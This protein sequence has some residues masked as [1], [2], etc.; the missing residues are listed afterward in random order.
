[1]LLKMPTQTPTRI[2]DVDADADA[3]AGVNVD[4]D[5]G[6]N[7]DADA[8]ADSVADAGADADADVDADA[9]ADAIED[10]GADPNAD[11][12]GDTSTNVGCADGV[13]KID[14]KVTTRDPLFLYPKNLFPF[15]VTR[16]WN[17]FHGSSIFEMKKEPPLLFSSFF[18]FQFRRG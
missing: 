18:C 6:A 13:A 4:A 10:A 11:A 16:R 8:G 15:F 14:V 3:D 2:D 12:S 5:A 1:M 7:A 17:F 9:D